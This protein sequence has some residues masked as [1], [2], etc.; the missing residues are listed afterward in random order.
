MSVQHPVACVTEVCI[1]TVNATLLIYY[2]LWKMLY[3]VTCFSLIFEPSSGNILYKLLHL[4]WIRCFL[5]LIAC[6]YLRY[7]VGF[8]LF[9][10]T[11]N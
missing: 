10:L 7:L 8:I 4:Q 3:I 11:F 5:G 9:I 2:L 1:G 6:L